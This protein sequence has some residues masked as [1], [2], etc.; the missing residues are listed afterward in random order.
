M[1]FVYERSIKTFFNVAFSFRTWYLFTINKN[2][3]VTP[4]QNCAV[5]KIL[6]MKLVNVEFASFFLSCVHIT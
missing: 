2:K 3:K 5:F 4:W 6:I 1:T